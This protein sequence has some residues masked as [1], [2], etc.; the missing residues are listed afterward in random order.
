[1]LPVFT[2][3]TIRIAIFKLTVSRH[4]MDTNPHQCRHNLNDTPFNS[5][6]SYYFGMGEGKEEAR[7][8]FLR[9]GV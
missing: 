1:M 6:L 8:F 9:K 3:S 4:Q 5:F 2:V 7:G